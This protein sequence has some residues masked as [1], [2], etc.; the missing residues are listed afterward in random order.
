VKREF[1][2]RNNQTEFIKLI[3]SDAQLRTC[4]PEIAF[5]LARNN[6]PND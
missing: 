1:G 4:V 3:A 5:L 6:F 2:A